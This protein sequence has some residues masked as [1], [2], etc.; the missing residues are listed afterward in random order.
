MAKVAG[1]KRG[2]TFP[3]DKSLAINLFRCPSSSFLFTPLS[4]S[5]SFP[6]TVILRGTKVDDKPTHSNIFPNQEW[7]ERQRIPLFSLYVVRLVLFTSKLGSKLCRRFRIPR[8]RNL[9]PRN[10]GS[11][12]Y[13]LYSPSRRGIH[14]WLRES[15]W[16]IERA[17]L[18]NSIGYTQ[19]YVFSYLDWFKYSG[20]ETSITI[21][22]CYYQRIY[23]EYLY[24][25]S[26][27]SKIV[28]DNSIFP[29]QSYQIVFFEDTFLESRSKRLSY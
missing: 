24:I 8:P 28:N 4:L 25:N 22:H 26:R 27:N 29:V 17:S 23:I 7:W 20:D 12:L 2:T 21:K 11:R 5:L 16:K 1:A 19:T 15:L 9:W 14:G 10:D 13:T 3:P 6:P 18:G